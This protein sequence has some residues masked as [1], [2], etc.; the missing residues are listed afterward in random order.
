M[1]GIAAAATRFAHLLGL[2]PRA[3]TSAVAIKAAVD[4]DEGMSAAADDDKEPEQRAD[5][6]EEDFAKRLKAW[7]KAKKAD[8]DAA[9]EDEDGDK[10]KEAKA[11]ARGR[12]AG[13]AAE[14]ARCSAIFAAPAAK[15]IPHI[16]ASLAFETNLPTAEAISLMGT[17]AAAAPAARRTGLAEAMARVDVP[18]P[19]SDS[20]EAP[21]PGDTK[22]VAAAI[23][24]A[25]KKARGEA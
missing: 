11:E 6:S 8:E 7:K 1:A 12:K 9:A 4:D 24:A 13:R 5:E 17:F 18:N 19:G 16:A 25:G 2:D 15:G 21:A 14:R 3:S 23:V 22:S 20:G 10:D